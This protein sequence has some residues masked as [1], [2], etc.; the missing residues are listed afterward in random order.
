VFEKIVYNFVDELDGQFPA[1]GLV[2]NKDLTLYGTASPGGSR[3]CGKVF[4]LTPPPTPGEVWTESTLY[5]F[6]GNVD[7]LRPQ[8]APDD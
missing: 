5:S 3:S 4:K 1:A 2:M 6:R 7:G 8:T